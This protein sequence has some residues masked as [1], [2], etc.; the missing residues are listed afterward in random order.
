MRDYDKTSDVVELASMV[1][2]FHGEKGTLILGRSKITPDA[3]VS[4]HAHPI[5][6]SYSRSQ[7]LQWRVSA[8]AKVQNV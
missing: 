2:S 4:M 8:F 7:R 6:Q 3:T 5:I 1:I